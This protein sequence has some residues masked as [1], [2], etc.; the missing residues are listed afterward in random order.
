ME[1]LHSK[2]VMGNVLLSL[3]L[4]LRDGGKLRV[5]FSG[6]MEE[7]NLAHSTLLRAGSEAVPLRGLVVGFAD[8]WG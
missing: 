1:V 3:G 7:G 6:G 5:E 4:V 2:S 8:L